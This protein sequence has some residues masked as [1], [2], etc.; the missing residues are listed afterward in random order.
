MPD[1]RPATV[2]DIK[3]LARITA[4]AF[5]A[6]PVMTWV[7]P[8]EAT[9]EAQL[10]IAFTGLATGFLPDLGAVHV[11]DDA[12]AS[13]WRA[14][15]YDYDAA[16][17][18][19]GPPGPSPFED[20]VT[21]RFQILSAAMAAVHPHETPHWYLNVLGTVPVRQGQGLGAQ[22]L[23][24]VLMHCNVDGVAAYLE[25]SNARNLPFY[26]R[27]GFVQTGE[28]PLPDGPSLYP[29]WREPGATEVTMGHG[30]L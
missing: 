11:I 15:D 4:A 16:A 28:I 30:A 1:P 7:I 6:D 23:A 8:N 5:A 19:D 13:F 12:C 10:R 24:P 17:P 29:M 26:R 22:V 21:E 9:R 25:S 18:A 20:G 14:P 3:M 27:Q 2:D